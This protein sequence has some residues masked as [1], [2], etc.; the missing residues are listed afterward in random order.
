MAY[1][2]RIRL[3]ALRAVSRLASMGRPVGHGTRSDPAND[4]S[5]MDAS[6]MSFGDHLEE[7]R[8]CLIRALVGVGAAAA[9]CLAVGDH[10]LALLYRPLLLVQ[11]SQG[12]PTQL[13][14]L[15][16]TAGFTTYMK[17]SLLAG[18][19]ISMPWILHQVWNFIA[20]G[21]YRGER[22]FVSF[23]VPVSAGLF[24]LGVLFLYF[25]VLPMMLQFF[26]AFNRAMV[27]PNLTPI[28][29]ERWLL[30]S[31]PKGDGGDGVD[32]HLSLP[33]LATDPAKPAAGEAWINSTTKRLVV[34]TAE[35]AFST[36][37]TPG[38]DGQILESFFSLDAYVSFVLLLA[39]A[40]GLAFET[41]V[42]VFFLIWTGIVSVEA[43]TGQRRIV[44]LALVFVAAV[45]TPPDVLSLCML[46]GPMWLLFEAGVLA[47]R[48]ATRRRG[49]ASSAT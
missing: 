27:V 26:I 34:Q 12:L 28:G 38:T 40:F 3:T 49:G 33:V 35:G 7:L 2:E 24:A 29:P 46:A 22:R 44:I 39:L 17:I 1:V 32:T 13:Q 20:T 11:R 45:I 4:A 8:A 31:A 15:S 16:P 43:I 21:L 14:S 41:P 36:A 47:G 9:F 25:A 23:A 37:L 48:W 19:V 5:A 18:L 10:I 42:V 30:P 6:R